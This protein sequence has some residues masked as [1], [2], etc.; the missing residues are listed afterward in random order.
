MIRVRL[1]AAVA[2]VACVAGVAATSPA[3]AQPADEH[4]A[5]ATIVK[6]LESDTAHHAVTAEALAKANNALERATRM[7]TAGDEAHAK[8]ADGLAL[9]WAETAR[10]L[11]RAADAEATAADLR[12]KALD[13][14]AQLE[15]SRALVE[16]AIASIGRLGAELAQ[17]DGKAHTDRTAVEIHEGSPPPDKPGKQGDKAN[18]GN[19]KTDGTGKAAPPPAA[20]TPSGDAGRTP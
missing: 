17:A 18:K 14:Q 5:A 8:A 15:R 12:H 9:E 20:P 16:E 19:K 11:V 10:D 2:S 4:S 6:Q 3:A 1:F 7:R 13:A